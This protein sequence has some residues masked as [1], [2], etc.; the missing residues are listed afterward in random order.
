MTA[1]R[2]H[3]GCDTGQ[4]NRRFTGQVK[5]TNPRVVV[6]DDTELIDSKS[7]SPQSEELNMLMIAEGIVQNPVN[8]QERRSAAAWLGPMTD[9]GFLHGGWIET[10]GHRL[11]M[12]VSAANLAEAQQRLD[13]LPPARAGS[14]SFTLTRVEALRIS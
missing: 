3:S 1:P 4:G 14:V 12:L 6:A 13:D 5:T 11:W 10:T 9:A 2:G 8:D 7:P